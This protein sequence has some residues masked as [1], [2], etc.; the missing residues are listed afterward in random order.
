M[1]LATVVVSGD[2]HGDLHL[3]KKITEVYD[4]GGNCLNN[5]KMTEFIDCAKYAIYEKAVRTINCTAPDLKGLFDSADALFKKPPCANDN[6]RTLTL[7]A[8]IDIIEEFLQN[9]D[10]FNCT[11][12]CSITSYSVR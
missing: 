6:E 1:P 2:A 10:A 3:E 12:P 8:F 5:F 4:K 9:I 7:Y 11:L